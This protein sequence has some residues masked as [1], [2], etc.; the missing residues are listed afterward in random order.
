MLNVTIDGSTA[1]IQLDDGK[2]NAV[3][4]DFIDAMNTGLDQAEK[5]A[6]VALITGRE[7]L[8]SA[9]FDLKEIEKGPEASAALVGKGAQMLLRIFSHPQPV[10]AASAGHA[11]AA[12]ALIML[13]ADTRLGAA[14]NFK[15]GLNETAIGMGLPE[16][17][18]QLAKAR[19]SMRHQTQAVIQGQLFDP[20]EARD[21][22]FLDAVVEPE[23]LLSV[24]LKQASE[25][26]ELPAAAYSANKLG[27]RAPYITAIKA[28]LA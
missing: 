7:G 21:V 28:S 26:A 10:V 11:I 5:D 9:G 3:G 14:G 24:A 2:A 4:H 6:K 8:F 15:L 16:F 13:A 22:G 17:G 19:L 1:L 23:D 12:G 27:L 18:L 25:L 20:N